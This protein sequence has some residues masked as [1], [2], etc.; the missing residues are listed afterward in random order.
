MLFRSECKLRQHVDPED[1]AKLE[2]WNN[3]RGG[4]WVPDLR[5]SDSRSGSTD[6]EDQLQVDASKVDGPS[7]EWKKYERDWAGAE[8]VWRS[9]NSLSLRPAYL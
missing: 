6:R 3:L 8:G 5:T 1:I 9:V 4:A 2:D 7:E